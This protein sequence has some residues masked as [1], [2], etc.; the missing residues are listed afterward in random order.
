MFSLGKLVKKDAFFYRYITNVNKDLKIKPI[1]KILI[2]NRGEIACRVMRTAKSKGVKTVAVYSEADKNSLHVS[3]ADESYLIGPAAAK[4]SYLCGNKIIDVAKRSGAQAIHP[5]YGFLSENSDFA[6]LCEREGIIFIGPPSD[7]IKAMGSKSASKDIMIKAGVPTIPGYHGEDQSM[8][9]LKSEAAKIGY[10]VLIKAVMGGGGKGMRI[11]EREE[12]LED[13]VESS[14]R[15]ATASFGDSRVLVEKYLVHPRHV[16]IQ[17]FADRHGNCVHLFERDCS[18]QRRHQKIIE[19]AP[20][21]HLSEELRKKMGD[22]AVAAAKAVGYVGAGTVEFI[23]SADNSFFFM[24][25]NTRLQVEHPITEMITKQDLVEWQLKVAESQTLPMEQEQLKIHGHSFEAR[26]YAENP[27]SD[28]LP[29]TGKLA[30]LSTPTPSD[31]LRVETGVRQGDE[32]SVYYDPMIAKLVVWDQDREKAL[33]Y[34]RNA[35]DEYHIIGLN[36]NISFLK[37]LSTHPSFMAGE[38]ETGFIPIHRESLMAPQ[39][40]MSDDSLALAATSLLLK[41]ITQQ[42]SK[43]DPNSPWS[44]LGGFRINHNLKKQV[45]FNQKDNKVVVNVEFIGGGGAAANGKHNFK[46]TLDNGN[47]VEVLDAKLNQNNETISAHVNGRFYNNIKSVIVKDTLTIFN[48]GQQYQLDIPQDVKPKGAD[49][50]LGSLVSPMPGKI[51]K[52]MVNVGDMVKKGQPILLMEA[53]KMEHTI[54]SPIDGKVES[55]P[56]NVNEIV[57]DKKTLAVIV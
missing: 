12:D 7:A 1:T 57:E 20:A 16:E 25:M 32:V 18:V 55:L 21:P 37:R 8:S 39:A 13:G 43:E 35:L 54:R 17:V 3:M 31:T 38:V 28:F 22:A 15:E 34:L 11:V 27:D 50:V 44:S 2:A 10:P 42:K 23:L 46:V 41:E 4:E 14:K 47:V 33:R 48:E 30:H 24:E 53:M 36:T 52:V 9:V 49:G 29:G 40:P 45:K 51:T 56:Y 6:D 26:I 5:G 19:E